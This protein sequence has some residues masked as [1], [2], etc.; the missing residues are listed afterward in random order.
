MKLLQK[1]G[2]QPGEGL[3]RNKEGTLEPLALDI[4]TDKKGLVSRE[5]VAPKSNANT[6]K[7][8][9]EFQG[10]HPVSILHELCTKRRWEPPMFEQVLDVGP[11]HQK[12]FLFKVNVTGVEYRPCVAS[13][14]KPEAKAQS[15]A[16]C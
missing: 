10:K 8:M 1:M 5:E 13:T 11:D 14:T 15:A 3:G 6:V 2:W 12:H 9:Q 16:V 4:K 7:L